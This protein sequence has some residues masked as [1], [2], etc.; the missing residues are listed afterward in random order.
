VDGALRRITG[1]SSLLIHRASAP[2]HTHSMKHITPPSGGMLTPAGVF[3]LRIFT[4]IKLR[5]RPTWALCVCPWFIT[6]KWVTLPHIYFHFISPRY[7]TVGGR[8][9]TCSAKYRNASRDLPI[10]K[11]SEP[12]LHWYTVKQVLY[13]K[14]DSG[15]PKSNLRQYVWNKKFWEELIAYFPWYDTGHIE[16]DA[17]NNSSTVACVFVTAVTFLPSRC[18]AT[19]GGIHIQTH[20]LMGGIF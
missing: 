14:T 9:N 3:A 6:L 5:S 19:I 13:F 16:N 4:S 8:E 18:L 10:N 7:R 1:G 11:T 15:V 17:T 2:W 12:T 20:R